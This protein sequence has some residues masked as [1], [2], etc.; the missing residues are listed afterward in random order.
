MS[1]RN[2]IKLGALCICLTL[3]SC[4][5]WREARRERIEYQLFIEE[6]REYYMWLWENDRDGFY[7]IMDSLITNGEL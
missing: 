7:Y 6:E 2:Y 5:S 1:V 4:S 3:V